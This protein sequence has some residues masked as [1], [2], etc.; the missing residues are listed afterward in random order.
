MQ[1]VYILFEMLPMLV[2]LFI[3]LNFMSLINNYTD[4][5]FMNNVLSLDI[6]YDKYSLEYFK[7]LYLLSL[8]I[9]LSYDDLSENHIK[10]IDRLLSKVK[11]SLLLENTTFFSS[12]F[13]GEMFNKFIIRKNY[14]KDIDYKSR[15]KKIIK[16]VQNELKKEKE[17]FG[18]NRREKE[19]FSSLLNENSLDENSKKDIY[20]LKEIFV[21][22]YEELILKEEKSDKNTKWSKKLTIIS[23]LYAILISLPQLKELILKVYQ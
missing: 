12:T 6:K 23:L 1:I 18:L 8:N 5:K 19:I 9:N 11:G 17:L 20:E 14:E 3:L 21:N 13:I 22:R 16:D 10:K 7:N 15:L 2:V 4:T